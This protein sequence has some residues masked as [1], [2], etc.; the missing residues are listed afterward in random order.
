MPGARACRTNRARRERAGNQA[1]FPYF[2]E[3]NHA[4]ADPGK[5]EIS[6]EVKLHELNVN[7]ARE[8]GRIRRLPGFRVAR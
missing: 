7:L 2:P 5:R 8:E 3:Y 4:N 6:M 1:R